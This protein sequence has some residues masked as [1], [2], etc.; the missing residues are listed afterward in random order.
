MLY[1]VITQGVIAVVS[2]RGDDWQARE[3][4]R[5][6]STFVHEI[7]LGD[8]DGDGVLEVYATLVYLRIMYAI[9]SDY[10]G[11]SVFTGAMWHGGGGFARGYRRVVYLGTHSPAAHVS[12]ALQ[13][14]ST[15]HG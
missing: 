2:H 3:L 4:Y 1:E 6:P 15:M 5:E 8:L 10:E 14:V 11:R 12:L 9:R 7:E 13:S